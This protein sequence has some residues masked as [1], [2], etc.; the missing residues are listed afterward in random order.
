M[1]PVSGTVKVTEAKD[2]KVVYEGGF[3]VKA[4]AINDIAKLD[5][6]GQGLFVIEYKVGGETLCNHYL[7]GEPPFSW[8]EYKQW[9]RE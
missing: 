9:R 1:E 7:Y 3:T 2:G 8:S 5:W 4:N 6:N